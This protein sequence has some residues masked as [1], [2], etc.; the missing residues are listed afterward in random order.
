MS[1][2]QLVHGDMYHEILFGQCH[3]LIHLK[4][5]KRGIYTAWI[6]ITHLES[7]IKIADFTQIVQELIDTCLVIFDEGIEGHH[8]LFLGI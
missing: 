1:V 8:V 5:H 7:I 6:T 3:V 2:V 4:R